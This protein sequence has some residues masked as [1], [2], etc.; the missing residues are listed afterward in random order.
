[1]SPATKQSD[2]S[3]TSA[4]SQRQAI[5][6]RLR[7]GPATTVELAAIA[8]KYTGRVSELRQAGHVITATPIEGGVYRY[9]LV[10]PGR[11]LVCAPRRRGLL[12]PLRSLD[13]ELPKGVRDEACPRKRGAWHP[14]SD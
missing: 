1:M 12:P 10:E 6:D 3:R 7:R 5:L 14:T 2:R 9:T 13:G 4:A 8:L 11:R